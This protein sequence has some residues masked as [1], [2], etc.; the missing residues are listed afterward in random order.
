VPEE[1]VSVAELP[2]RRDLLAV[3]ARLGVAPFECAIAGLLIVFG[4]STI[5]RWGAVS[6]ADALLPAWETYVLAGCFALSGLLILAGVAV[7]SLPAETA[8]LLMLC[9]TLICRLI[10]YAIYLGPGSSTFILA[11]ASYTLFTGGA[12]LRLFTMHRRRI[13]IIEIRRGG[14]GAAADHPGDSGPV[15]L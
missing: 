15:V 2:R 10:L 14:A 3:I 4:A 13:I 8:G 12:F 9:A 1:D 7:P 6:P 5:F 11:G